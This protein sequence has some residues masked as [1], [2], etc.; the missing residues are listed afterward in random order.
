MFKDKITNLVENSPVF[1][2]KFL[3]FKTL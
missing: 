1:V 3:N 2:K